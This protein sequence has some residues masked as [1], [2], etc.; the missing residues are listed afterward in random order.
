MANENDGFPIRIE[1]LIDLISSIKAALHNIDSTITQNSEV[2][3]EISQNIN[4]LTEL[5]K[6]QNQD[7]KSQQLKTDGI[8]KSIDEL[9]NKLELMTQQIIASN[10]KVSSNMT[11][12]NTFKKESIDDINKSLLLLSENL[13]DIQSGLCYLKDRESQKE[14]VSTMVSLQ[15]EQKVKEKKNESLGEEV[16]DAENFLEKAISFV[17]NL[18]QGIGTLYKILMLAVGLILVILWLTGVITA[19]DLKNIGGLKFF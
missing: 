17:K 6:K 12:L 3:S 19:D 5:Y 7:N 16:K 2:L 4:V 1:F 8:A 9:T 14:L 10:E 11:I 18:S 15:E 13:L